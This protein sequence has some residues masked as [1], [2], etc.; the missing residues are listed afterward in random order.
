[1]VTIIMPFYKKYQEFF[2][3]FEYHNYNEFNRYP[4]IELIISVDAPE[5]I[6]DLLSYLKNKTHDCL[7][8]IKVL[9]NRESHDWRCPSIAINQGIQQA[10]YEKI[11]VMSPETIALPGSIDQLQYSC[12]NQHF[13]L[14]VIKHIEAEGV[15]F[16][17]INE[18]FN[19]ISSPI[20]PYGSI[21]FRKT[22]AQHI[23]GYN[24][25]FKTWGGDDDDFRYRLK[26]A[27][28]HKKMTL[29]KFIHIKYPQRT[30]NHSSD[31]IKESKYHAILKKVNSIS[32]TTCFQVHSSLTPA[33]KIFE[34]AFSFTSV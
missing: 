15:D 32:K 17:N 20:L 33:K 11:L 29:A 23:G 9:L 31:K 25:D 26:L 8:S 22:Q 34:E 6:E 21:C 10:R 16:S 13:S 3:S 28:Y 30:I 12:D 24:E 7:F 1:M 18:S 5:E 27:G 14:G 2:T 4:M 19:A